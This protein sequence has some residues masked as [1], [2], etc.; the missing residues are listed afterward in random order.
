MV[1]V[2]NATDAENEGPKEQSH[3]KKRKHIYVSL[4]DVNGAIGRNG[5]IDVAKANE[6]NAAI[7]EANELNAAIEEANELNVAI[8]EANELN[9]AIKEVD[10]LNAA[11]EE[12]NGLNVAIEEVTDPMDIDQSSISDSKHEF[13]PGRHQADWY[14]DSGANAHFCSD[15]S[16]FTQY[17]PLP[18]RSANLAISAAN[19]PIQGIGTVEID[20]ESAHGINTLKVR[21]VYY[22]PE[23]RINVLSPSVIF[24]KSGI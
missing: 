24:S 16:Q 3:K 23:I 13:E 17:R 5:A 10:G 21:D 1:A 18:N 14:L 2:A 8:E 12:A 22:S 4:L 7:E 20:L 11:I 9:A 15:L 6:L 19:M